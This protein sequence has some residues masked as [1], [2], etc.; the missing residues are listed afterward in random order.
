[1][2]HSVASVTILLFFCLYR[3]TTQLHYIMVTNRAKLIR[4]VDGFAFFGGPPAQISF[5]LLA[6]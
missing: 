4:S 5:S 6:N 3:Y 1:M 2:Q